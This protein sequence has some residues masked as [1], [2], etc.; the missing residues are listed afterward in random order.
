MR[1]AG[2]SGR[3]GM[4]GPYAGRTR[5]AC[6]VRYPPRAP[7][8]HHVVVVLSKLLGLES[9]TPHAKPNSVGLQQHTP[10]RDTL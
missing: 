1:L 2:L 4:D 5:P 3:T 7:S 10:C 9:I 6:A 8:R